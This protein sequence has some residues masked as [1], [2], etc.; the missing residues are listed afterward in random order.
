MAEITA[1]LVKQLRERTGAGFM[2]CKKALAEAGG[3]LDKAAETLRIKGLAQAAKKAGRAATE[4]VVEAYIHA[5]GKI[6]VLVEVNC[7][8]DF[9]ARTPE[10]KQL[11][12]EI[13]MQVAATNPEYVSKEDVPEEAVAKEREILR[14]QALADGKPERVVDRIVEGR[15]DK[16]YERI[17]LLEQ[18][19]IRE[20]GMK[21]GDLVKQHV[22]KLGENVVVRRFARFEVGRE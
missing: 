6:G 2:D 1:D 3:D 11:A 18:P 13:A 22:A 10:F 19:Y 21:V 7:E 4:G 16:F 14:A 17:C 20:P 15:L 12:H 5:G 8:T 9:V